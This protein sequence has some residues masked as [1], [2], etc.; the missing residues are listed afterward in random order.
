MPWLLL[1]AAHEVFD[2]VPDLGLCRWV[3]GAADVGT[4]VRTCRISR[5]KGVRADRRDRRR[6]P[7]R[8][9]PLGGWPAESVPDADGNESCSRGP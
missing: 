6:R 2:A 8:A 5:S 7:R 4:R 1:R 9:F 3:T